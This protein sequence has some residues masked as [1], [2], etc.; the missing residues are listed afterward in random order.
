M[1]SRHKPSSGMLASGCLRPSKHTAHA[2][3]MYLSRESITD[4][5]DPQTQPMAIQYH[6]SQNYPITTQSISHIT[7]VLP[8][9]AAVL[10]RSPCFTSFESTCIALTRP[11]NIHYTT[12]H[13]GKGRKHARVPRRAS[14][15]E[16]VVGVGER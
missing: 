4:D 8:F 9:R 2:S 7:T 6:M 12:W 11:G 3:A 5:R 14:G 13:R 16:V 10:H 1:P 15:C